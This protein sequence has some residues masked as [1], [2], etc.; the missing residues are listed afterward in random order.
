MQFVLHLFGREVLALTLDVPIPP[1]I[2]ELS[3]L[4]LVTPEEV[5]EEYEE[6]EPEDRTPMRF[7]F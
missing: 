3:S 6:E 7:G 2:T 4:Q 5:D 1:V